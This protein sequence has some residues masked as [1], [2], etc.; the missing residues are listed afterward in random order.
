MHKRHAS[1]ATYVTPPIRNLPHPTPPH[2][3]IVKQ[4]K[5]KECKYVEKHVIGL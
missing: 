3:I 1:S 2:P 5:T 4:Y